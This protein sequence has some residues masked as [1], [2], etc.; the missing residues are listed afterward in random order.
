MKKTLNGMTSYELYMYGMFMEWDIEYIQF[1]SELKH[2]L[3]GELTK[4]ETLYEEW[5]NGGRKNEIF[6]A[7]IKWFD[8]DIN[9]HLIR[10]CLQG[11]DG[12]LHYEDQ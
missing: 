2:H 5:N 7:L 3:V 10:I 9:K 4:F 8:V 12:R 6:T 11:T 1:D